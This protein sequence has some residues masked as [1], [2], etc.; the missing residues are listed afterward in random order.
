MMTKFSQDEVTEIESRTPLLKSGK[1]ITDEELED[2]KHLSL[3]MF[4]FV[5]GD[6]VLG[7]GAYGQ[8][9]LVRDI[10]TREKFALKII[11]KSTLQ[12][13]SI[14]LMREV[15]IHKRLKHKNIVRLVNYFEDKKNLY[16]IL[17]YCSKG[18]L[19]HLIKKRKRLSEKEAFFYW[20]QA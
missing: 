1:F 20:A 5:E 15:E 14:D 17:E 13:K 3:D 11:S 12:N 19:F 9:K 8:V 2:N 10:S 7:K 16:L 6:K 18:S 4:E